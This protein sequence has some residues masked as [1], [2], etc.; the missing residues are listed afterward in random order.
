MYAVGLCVLWAQVK[1][2]AFIGGVSRK[3]EARSLAAENCTDLELTIR[4]L[5]FVF[6]TALFALNKKKS[7]A[8][9]NF[10]NPSVAHHGAS[11][12]PTCNSA[13]VSI[14]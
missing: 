6:F 14:N 7:T 11:R 4:S 1:V 2:T 3:E 8:D 12:T 9:A 5:S 10:K 13:T